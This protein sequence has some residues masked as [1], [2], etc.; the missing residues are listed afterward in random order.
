MILN[1][2]FVST[3]AEMRAT[4]NDYKSAIET[5]ISSISLEQFLRLVLRT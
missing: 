2:D 3:A 5:T 4:L 1:I